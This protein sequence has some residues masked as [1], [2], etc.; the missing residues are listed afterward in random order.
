MLSGAN[1]SKRTHLVTTMIARVCPKASVL[2]QSSAKLLPQ[3]SF[4]WTKEDQWYSS[5]ANWIGQRCAPTNLPSWIGS[6][7]GRFCEGRS[8]EPV[9]KPSVPV[10]GDRFGC[11]RRRTCFVVFSVR[12]C[13]LRPSSV[14]RKIATDTGWG[15]RAGGGAERSH[16]HS[17]LLRTLLCRKESSEQSLEQVNN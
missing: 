10:E 12:V 15:S 5:L 8:L 9:S 13:A 3:P 1:K 17:F 7:L 6:H 11:E 2:P 16:S 4:S 14:R